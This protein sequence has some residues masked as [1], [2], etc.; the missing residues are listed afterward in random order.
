MNIVYI[1][2]T[3]DV[4][5]VLGK[6]QK[7]LPNGVKSKIA[8]NKIYFKNEGEN[9]EC[10]Y[11]TGK[12]YKE[13][14]IIKIGQ[15]ICSNVSGRGYKTIVLSNDV[16][17]EEKICEQLKN[18]NILNGRWLFNYIAY[19]VIEYILQKKNKEI[20]E[21]EIS[22][23]V[24]ETTDINVQNIFRIAENVKLLNVVTENISVFKQIEEKLL[25][26]KGIMIRVTNN[27][28]KVLLKSDVILNLDFNEEQ[29][30][31]YN[32]PNRGIIVNVNVPI[33]NMRKSFNGVNVNGYNLV[34]PQNYKRENFDD[35]E[36]YES[37]LYTKTQYANIV[38]RIIQD[39]VNI[40][41]L[42]G[43]NG[44]IQEKEYELFKNA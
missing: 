37:V 24:N 27:K 28:K 7:K 23:L 26:E 40:K 20:N 33:K 21:A 4:N 41:N 32:I 43:N 9:F 17:L 30:R 29:F 10:K 39:N 36:M 13:K 15:R 11:Y 25:N 1:S 3:S 42:V 34:I 2:K 16:K 31:K 5:D 38:N 44:I 35:T 19:D 22:I 12:K 8:K 18:L 6:F 14:D